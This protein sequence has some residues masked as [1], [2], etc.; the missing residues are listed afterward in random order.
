[1]GTLFDYLDWRGDL[2][3]SEAPIN[4]ID[5]LIFTQL[6]YVS[7]DGIVPSEFDATPISLRDAVRLYLRRHKGEAAY[8]GRIVP[9]AIVSL[10]AKAAKTQRYANVKMLAYTNHIDEKT[11]TQFS[12]I[13]FLPQNAPSYVAYRGTDD[14]LVG[15]KED[16][17]MSV[18]KEIPGQRHA[19]EY[20]NKV[21]ETF[22]GKIRIG[23]HSKGGNLAV[24]AAAKCHPSI[25]KR[26]V[27]VYN[28]DG[29][30]FSAEFIESEGYQNIK[31]KILKLIPQESIVGLLLT[32][33]DHFS[34]V[35]SS[36]SGV[37]QHNSFLWEIR[38]RHFIRRPALAQKS[39]ELSK[40]INTWINE[41][42]EEK[43]YDN[44]AYVMAELNIIHP[45]REGN[46]RTIREF[47]RLMAKRLNY[48]LNWGN[49]DKE[50]LSGVSIMSI[51]D[52]TVLIGLLEACME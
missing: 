7:F 36:K 6:S 14:T 30:G 28:N 25:Q 13:T 18:S 48:D 21:A 47:I 37:F 49:V 24:Y 8:L 43:I 9:S 20:L 44:L 41:K 33:D 11:Q 26:I 51:T 27:R 17:K 4:E 35:L 16:L 39:I 45:F 23:G 31:P 12:A 29:P 2:R 52:Y 34:V 40:T 5:S 32:N 10:A 3:F 50:E 38:G 1:M 46:G 19:L 15:W 42:D 22:N